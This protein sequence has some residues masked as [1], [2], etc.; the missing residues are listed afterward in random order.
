[1]GSLLTPEEIIEDFKSF[2]FDTALS[3]HETTLAFMKAFAGEDR[4]LFGTDFPGIAVP[5]CHCWNG[6]HRSCGSQL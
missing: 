2:Y 6:S 3:S 5:F 4:I 1:M